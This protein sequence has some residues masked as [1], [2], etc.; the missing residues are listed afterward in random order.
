MHDSGSKKR[1]VARL[2]VLRS[3]FLRQ[4]HNE[5]QH[6]TETSKCYQFCFESSDPIAEVTEALWSYLQCRL[7]WGE[8]NKISEIAGTERRRNNGEARTQFRFDVR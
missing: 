2:G 5:Q 6:A 8:V 4:S 3:E 7:R 1:T